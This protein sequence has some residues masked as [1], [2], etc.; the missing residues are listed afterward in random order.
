MEKSEAMSEAVNNSEQFVYEICKKSF[1][2]LWSYVNPQGRTPQKELCDVLVVCDP[3]IIVISVKDIQL[4]SSDDPAVG[5]KRWQR[6]AIDDSIKQIKGAVRWLEQSEYVVQKDGSKGLKLPSK[7]QRIYHNIAVAFGGQRE[8]PFAS[9]EDESSAFYHVIDEQSFFLLL[10][11]LDTITDFVT[12]LS[13]KENFLSKTSAVISGGEENLLAVY[14]HNGRQFPSGEDAIFFENDLWEEVSGKPEF[15]AKLQKDRVSYIWDKLIELMCAGGFNGESWLGPDLS[16][17][18]LALRRL[19]RENRF[20]RRLLGDAF[21][22][23]LNLSKIGQVRSRCIHSP[24]EVGYVFFTYDSD[25]TYEERKSELLGRC[26]AVIHQ[27]ADCSTIVGMG[28]NVPGDSPRHGYSQ[29]LVMLHK[30]SD[31]WPE[32]YL[33][34]ADHCRDELGFFKKPNITH[35]H[36]DEYPVSE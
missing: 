7:N 19:A 25:S 22:N 9:F 24:S 28:I 21:I 30:D 14:L 23:F 5:W 15:S 34:Q 3:H 10:R 16:E 17:A 35:M 6:K 36:E 2:S 8:V 20:A 32:E 18:E 29:D 26:F 33:R 4:K 1:L 12:Y 13:D 11:H 31:K 27:F